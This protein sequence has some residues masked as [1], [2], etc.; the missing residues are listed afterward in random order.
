MKTNMFLIFFY[1]TPNN[2][3]IYRLQT[4]SIIDRQGAMAPSAV[5]VQGTHDAVPT[6][7]ISSICI[8][9]EAMK[10]IEENSAAT[11]MLSQ[12]Y[13][14]KLKLVKRKIEENEADLKEAGKV[15]EGL[16]ASI[17]EL[18][19]KVKSIEGASAAVNAVNVK[20]MMEMEEKH[21]THQMSKR[22]VV[23]GL[24]GRGSDGAPPPSENTDGRSAEPENGGGPE[25]VSVSS[26]SV[27]SIGRMWPSLSKA[28]RKEYAK[29]RRE[30]LAR[31]GEMKCGRCSYTG[32][33]D[34]LTRHIKR[35]EAWDITTRPLE[36]L[37]RGGP[38]GARPKSGCKTYGGKKRK[39]PSGPRST[40]S[41]QRR[42]TE[43]F[44][45][46]AG[47]ADAEVAVRAAAAEGDAKTDDTDGSGGARAGEEK[48][49]DEL[50]GK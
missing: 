19:K 16:R 47:V 11:D 34:L 30:K 20:L 41:T 13:I 43:L 48:K 3:R 5:D 10:V 49:K 2:V 14:E 27:K 39:T 4:Q 17:E 9:E 31:E 42:L 18:E 1:I 33:T 44:E 40:P 22:E 6:L 24:R 7:V 23:D 50:N 25:V 12:S 29:N 46:S 21:K 36:P 15:A 38:T 32:R 8:L 28:K 26:E 45:R 37:R 35:H